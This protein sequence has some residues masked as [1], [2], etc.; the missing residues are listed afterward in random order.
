ML[1]KIY[2]LLKKN[3]VELEDVEL[4]EN[5]SLIASGYMDSFEVVLILQKLEEVFKID[6]S[7]DDL[8]LEDFETPRKIV[9]MIELRGAKNE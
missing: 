9:N 6:I 1:N 3:V 7:L 8:N 5:T 2:E 4:E